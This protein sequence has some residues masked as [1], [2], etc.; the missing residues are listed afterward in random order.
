M[1]TDMLPGTKH[2]FCKMDKGSILY[3]GVKK[4]GMCTKGR[5]GQVVQVLHCKSGGATNWSQNFM[6]LR[7]ME[8]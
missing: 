1:V 2:T 3:F 5:R 8:K 4:P 7:Q 6:M